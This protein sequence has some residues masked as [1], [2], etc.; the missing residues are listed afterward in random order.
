[1][2]PE[3]QNNNLNL[4]VTRRLIMLIARQCV[5]YHLSFFQKQKKIHQQLTNNLVN[6]W[7]ITGYIKTSMVY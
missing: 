3:L 2:M 1:M 5:V 6:H 7:N 4:D